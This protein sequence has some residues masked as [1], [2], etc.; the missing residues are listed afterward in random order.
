MW[1]C[2]PTRR[3]NCLSAAVLESLCDK[4]SV[5][6]DPRIGDPSSRIANIVQTF[7]LLAQRP[8]LP[9]GPRHLQQNDL[10]VLHERHCQS[11]RDGIFEPRRKFF[12]CYAP[13]C[14]IDP[15]SRSSVSAAVAIKTFTRPFGRRRSE[16]LLNSF[17][18][19]CRLFACSSD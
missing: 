9:F 12:L 16:S 6:I 17:N 19:I 10:P 11:T 14:K 13:G 3:S 4:G 8:S 15:P 2:Y 18:E 7:P 1:L 5:S